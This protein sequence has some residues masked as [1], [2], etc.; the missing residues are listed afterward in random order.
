MDLFL[1]PLLELPCGLFGDRTT[2]KVRQYEAKVRQYGGVQLDEDEKEA[3]KMQPNFA[4][5]EEVNDLEFMANTEK[6]FN[7]L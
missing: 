6:T 2:A 5:Y 1:L 4:I 3:L 7:S